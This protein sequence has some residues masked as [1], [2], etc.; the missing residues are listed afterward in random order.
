RP[1]GGG[2]P[3]DLPFVPPPDATASYL[4]RFQRASLGVILAPP[5]GADWFEA[6]CR[7]QG[8]TERPLDQGQASR[9]YLIQKGPRRLIARFTT[10]AQ[11][12]SLALLELEA[13]P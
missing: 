5:R 9:S 11:R 12:S 8:F 1:S 3:W 4:E 7:A 2:G 10:D 6:A 13:G